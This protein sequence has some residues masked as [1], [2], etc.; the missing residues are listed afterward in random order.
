MSLAAAANAHASRRDE[1]RTRSQPSTSRRRRTLKTLG[2]R[3]V[4]FIALSL[5]S[6]LGATPA[7]ASNN[8][9]VILVHGFAGFGRSEMLGYKYW[10]G[11]NDLPTQLQSKYS[12]RMVAPAVVGPFSSNWDRAVELFYQIKGGCVDYGAAHSSLNGHYE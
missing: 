10:G 12:N 2:F 5:A 7:Q 9:P 11:L 3:R 1:D 6:L 4:L 8:Y